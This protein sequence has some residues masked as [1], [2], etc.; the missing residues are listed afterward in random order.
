LEHSIKTIFRRFVIIGNKF[1]EIS[2]MLT[3]GVMLTLIAYQIVLRYIFR[4]G[5]ST[6][7]ELVSYLY[8]WSIYLGMVCAAKDREHIAVT[9]LPDKFPPKAKA[10]TYFFAN[11]CWLY[12][13]LFVCYASITLI[14]KMIPLGA[15]TAVLQVYQYYF[16]L[17]LPI[18]F[19]WTSIYVIRDA[20]H[21]MKAFV[22]KEV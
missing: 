19:I 1:I 2:S 12:Y 13:N 14:N 20:V 8:I 22:G 4:H 9:M 17:I 21:Y 16:Y 5:D 3:L 11:A 18:S 15:K 6:A 10:L 7:N